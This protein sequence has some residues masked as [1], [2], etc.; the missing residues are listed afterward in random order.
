MMLMI[1]SKIQKKEELKR[2]GAE[3]VVQQTAIDS[4]HPE[5][6]FRA[7]GKTIFVVMSKW[8]ASTDT[9]NGRRSRR[10]NIPH[11]ISHVLINDTSRRMMQG[12]TPNCTNVGTTA[13]DSYVDTGHCEQNASRIVKKAT[14]EKTIDPNA[15]TWSQ[16]KGHLERPGIRGTNYEIWRE[17]KLNAVFTY[18]HE[19]GS[20][21]ISLLYLRNNFAFRV[22]GTLEDGRTV[23]KHILDNSWFLYLIYM[24]SCINII[25]NDSS[26][27]SSVTQRLH[28]SEPKHYH[29]VVTQEEVIYVI[30]PT[31]TDRFS[32][33]PALQN[34]H[35]AEKWKD[36]D[37]VPLDNSMM[38]KLQYLTTIKV[39]LS[40]AEM[41]V[42]AQGNTEE[43]PK[44]YL[45][46]VIKHAIGSKI[47]K[48][49]DTP[50]VITLFYN[51]MNITYISENYV[52]YG[53]FPICTNKGYEIFYRREAKRIIKPAEASKAKEI[54]AKPIADNNRYYETDV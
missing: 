13:I 23:V 7:S 1:L 50:D 38:N 49:N 39:D 32:N 25:E 36:V 51:N 22:G 37:V 18:F 44:G 28:Q 4:W 17:R 19:F 46:K 47:E 54:V 6:E 2:G 9:I 11:N 43:S 12:V 15:W 20:I 16:T 34:Q 26:S 48:Y 42:N 31:V 35:V 52:H 14:V 33:T 41:C 27:M 53:G 45:K 30:I 5:D 3:S 10:K 24:F 40:Y 21:Y 29:K 8:L